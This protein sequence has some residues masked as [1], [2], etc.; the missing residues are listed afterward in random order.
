MSGWRVDL[1][2]VGTYTEMYPVQ[3]LIAGLRLMFSGDSLGSP[4]FPG[5]GTLVVL[6]CT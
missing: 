6:V 4:A 1:G 5:E 3:K 2:T